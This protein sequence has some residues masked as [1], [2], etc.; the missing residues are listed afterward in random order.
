MPV[1][2]N[3][4]EYNRKRRECHCG[5][6]LREIRRAGRRGAFLSEAKYESAPDVKCESSLGLKLESNASGRS[7]AV[8][9]AK[10]K[11]IPVHFIHMMF[12]C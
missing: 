5:K 6:H 11:A 1:S 12:P 2:E 7:P 9:N 8:V 4:D 10:K 3:A